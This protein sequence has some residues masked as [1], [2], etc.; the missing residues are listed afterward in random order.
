MKVNH[1]TSRKF[2]YY[3]RLSARQKHIYDRSDSITSVKLPQAERFD[4]VT[5]DLKKALARED[6]VATQ[7]ASHRLVYGLCMVFGIRIAKIKV[8]AKRPSRNWGEMHGLYEHEEGSQP[9]ITVWMRTAKKKQ[10]VAF[11]TFLRTVIHEFMHHLD[12][13]HMK[14]ADSFHTE[15]FY[16]RES[17]LIKALLRE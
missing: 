16:K 12:Y 1:T 14:L 5:I 17:S 4:L 9:V 7:A 11:R 2:S 3:R 15:G 13:A 6:H 10:V 8:L